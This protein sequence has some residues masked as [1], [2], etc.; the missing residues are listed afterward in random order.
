MSGK[1]GAGPAGSGARGQGEGARLREAPAPELVAAAYR[2]E[3]ADAPIL[4]RGLALADLAHV[5]ALSEAAIVPRPDAARLLALLLEL[6]DVPVESFPLEESLED[7]YSNR[8]AWVRGRDEAV[9]GWLGAG[10]PRREPAT[11]A[12][13]IAV[14]DRQL[15][16]AASLLAC[17]R[18]LVDQASEHVHTVAPD[19]TYLQP[20]TPT[21][22]AHYLLSFAFPLLRDLERLEAAF[23][24]TNE[25]PGGIGNINGTRLPIDRARI[26]ELL[27]FERAI[28]H[29]RD[30]MWQ[31]DQPI[32][33]VAQAATALLHLERLAEDLQIWNTAEFGFVELADRH[34]R[35]SMIMP[36]KKNPYA[37]A[38]VRG[39]ASQMLGRLV[40]VAAVGRSPSGQMDNR[41]FALGD[42]PR[43]LDRAISIADLM[44]G[45]LAGL[46]FDVERLRARAGEG[47]TTAMDLAETIM[48]EAGV[49]YRQAH[50]L[51]GLAVR[52]ALERDPAAR[53]IPA[54]ILEE[55]AATVLGRPLD[56]PA[57]ALSAL[58]QPADVVKT[59]TG[60]G[61]AAEGPVK[62][63]I[64]QCRTEI[65]RAE[66][67]RARN[68][69]R[70]RQAEARL[71]A[72]ARERAAATSSSPAASGT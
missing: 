10:R 43:A 64:Q 52:L 7:V 46:R 13:R 72:I 53:T 36:Q 26:A 22:L 2:T 28:V 11:I 23:A 69:E 45:V 4:H 56:L 44:A 67:W 50:R 66:T 38:F 42:V 39:A 68:Q 63:M 16:L 35:I 32:E 14:R 27:G 15:A 40:S 25:C 18:A 54:A 33:V 47:F 65:S 3:L 37:L 31:V 21:S 49:G 8:E 34:A 12:Y 29:T 1:S 6:A 17:A 71:L 58:A 20:A 9:A 55:A 62:E 5:I 61:G 30:A 57:S 70:L 48:Q 41:V 51:V 60:M 19:Y 59:R 24:R